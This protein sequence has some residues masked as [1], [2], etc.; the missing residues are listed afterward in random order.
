MDG[1]GVTT[2]GVQTYNDPVTVGVDAA[3]VV[4]AE[5][6]YRHTVIDVG[7]VGGQSLGFKLQPIVAEDGC[8]LID[9]AT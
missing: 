7:D 5:G 9:S 1:G 2:S 4:R 6:S 3:P 8:G